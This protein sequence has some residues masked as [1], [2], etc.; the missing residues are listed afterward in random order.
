MNS[1]VMVC[2]AAVARSLS[3]SGLGKRLRPCGAHVEKNLSMFTSK[4]SGVGTVLTLE[5][6]LSVNINE[7]QRLPILSLLNAGNDRLCRRIE[8]C[9]KK[10]FCLKK[11]E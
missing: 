11:G 8:K 9:G 4:T 7:L 2:S 3:T 10:S 1:V 5:L 6:T